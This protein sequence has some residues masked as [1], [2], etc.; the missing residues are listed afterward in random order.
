MVHCQ[1]DRAC[2]QDLG[3]LRGHLEHLLISHLVDLARSLDDSWVACVDA[4]DVGIDVAAVSLERGRQ[5]H[6][7]RIGAAAAERRNAAIG[8]DALE[9]RHDRHFTRH[10]RLGQLDRVDLED[11]RL[12]MSRVGSDGQLPGHPGARLHAFLLQ[13]HRQQADRHLLAGRD[14]DVV[15]ARIVQRRDL[16]DPFH[17]LVGGSGHGRDH[18]RDLVAAR[19]LGFHLA[20]S[21]LDAIDVA[22]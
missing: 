10:H 21:I 14:D 4:I 19:H 20:R 16:V 2:L 3:A 22:D 9:A 5:G 8:S 12:G 17:Q 15:F 7:R 11:A 6:C 1:L 18:D 13:R